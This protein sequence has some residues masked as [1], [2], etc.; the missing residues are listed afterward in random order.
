MSDKP[1]PQPKL[2]KAT[3]TREGKVRDENGR[4]YTVANVPGQVPTAG[5]RVWIA[6]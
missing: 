2:R 1:K 3:A 4:T 5:S 6:R